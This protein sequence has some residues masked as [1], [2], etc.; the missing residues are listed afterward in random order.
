MSRMRC[1]NGPSKGRSRLLTGLSESRRGEE[2]IR[3]ESQHVISSRSGTD[4]EAQG[5]ISTTILLI[6]NALAAEKLLEAFARVIRFEP[7]LS[8][9]LL[10]VVASTPIPADILMQ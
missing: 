7:V 4:P 3:S 2:H 6:A 8:G 10:I 9:I 1:S 5:R